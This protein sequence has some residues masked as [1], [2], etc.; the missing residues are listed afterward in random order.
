MSVFNLHCCIYLSLSLVSD[1]THSHKTAAVQL[2]SSRVGPSRTCPADTSQASPSTWLRANTRAEEFPPRNLHR[3][4]H[5]ITPRAFF[6]PKSPVATPAPH[7]TALHWGVF[8]QGNTI[9]PSLCLA[10]KASQLWKKD[11]TEA[12]LAVENRR[13]KCLCRAKHCVAIGDETQVGEEYL[14]YRSGSDHAA[15]PPRHFKGERKKTNKKK[16][17]GA[18]T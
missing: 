9:H 12:S 13:H 7:R 18:V 10:E 14:W 6:S 5:I 17:N 15:L 8:E 16:N 2:F 4:F 11:H 3:T 1:T